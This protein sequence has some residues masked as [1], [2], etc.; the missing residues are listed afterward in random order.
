MRVRVRRG[1]VRVQRRPG[2]RVRVRQ[3]VVR[4]DSNDG[5]VVRDVRRSSA[6]F[7]R[8][9]A[10]LLRRRHEPFHAFRRVGSRTRRRRRARRRERRGRAA[11]RV[12]ASRRF[13]RRRHDENASFVRGRRHVRAPDA[14]EDV[15]RDGVLTGVRTRLL[16]FVVT[17]DPAEP[18]VRQVLVLVAVPR[19]E[20]RGDERRPDDGVARDDDGFQRRR[21][22]PDA[23]RTHAVHD[24]RSTAH[25]RVRVGRLRIQRGAGRTLAKRR[26]RRRRRRRVAVAVRLLF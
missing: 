13:G 15:A 24:Q 20:G 10:F 8:R 25:P 1:I 11:R 12:V 14:D 16:F 3:N 19:A 18:L 4:H 2:V 17:R 7:L 23:E 6:A 26:D 9:N 5:G 21:V 22:D